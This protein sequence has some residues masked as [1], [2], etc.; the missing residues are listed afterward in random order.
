MCSE[1][2]FT[3]SCAATRIS[4]CLHEPS[5]ACT[6]CVVTSHGLFS[7]KHSEKF[8]AIADTFCRAG[9]AVVRFDFSGCGD[10]SGR[11]ADT[12]VTGRLQQ[13]SAVVD[14]VRADALPG[15]AIGLL[16]SSLGGF[17]SLLYAS[18]HPVAALSCWATPFDLAAIDP[19]LPATDRA[20][21]SPAFFRDAA[22]WDMKK[23]IG[24]IRAIQFIHGSDD[25]L[26]P[27][28]HARRLYAAVRPPRDLHL[29]RG[30]DHRLSLPAWR[31]EALVRSRDWFVNQ[32]PAAAKG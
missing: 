13:L 3:L 23:T 7:S 31:H 20:R 21:L 28:T 10:S 24:T 8:L 32:L 19:R 26:V 6:A 15:R 5:Q 12:T 4:G 16:G 17:V 25:Q 11:I 22:S 29:I 2:P 9:M 18:R 1:S 30:G 27:A 14:W